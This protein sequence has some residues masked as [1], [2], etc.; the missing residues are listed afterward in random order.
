MSDMQTKIIS[1]NIHL[2]EL[3]DMGFINVINIFQLMSNIMDFFLFE[4]LK[5]VKFNNL[6]ELN[7]LN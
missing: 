2:S 5:S 7:Q 6:T 4:E 1:H 3:P